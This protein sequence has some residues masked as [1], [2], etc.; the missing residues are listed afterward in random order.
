MTYMEYTQKIEGAARAFA[1]QQR[2]FPA[3]SEDER[4]RRRKDY[5]DAVMALRKEYIAS[6]KRKR[7]RSKKAATA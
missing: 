3:R 2:F 4:K 5:H 7:T 6:A 1:S